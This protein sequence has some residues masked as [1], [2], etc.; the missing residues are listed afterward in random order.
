MGYAKLNNFRTEI[1]IE[2]GFSALYSQYRGTQEHVKN[3]VCKLICEAILVKSYRNRCAEN[4]K[5]Y[6]FFSLERV[7]AM[8]KVLLYNSTQTTGS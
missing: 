5:H 1:V 6:G 4:E 3:E 2:V 7:P 8:R